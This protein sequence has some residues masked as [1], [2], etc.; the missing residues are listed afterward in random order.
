MT[1][2]SDLVLQHLETL[3]K[4]R[5][6]VATAYHQGAV[7][8]SDDPAGGKGIENLR[9]A[10]ILLPRNEGSYRL[11]S[12]LMRHLDETLQ[13]ERLYSSSGA[14]LFELAQRLPEITNMV[15]DAAYEGRIEDADHY[16]DEFDLKVFEIADSVQASLVTLRFQCDNNF[17]NVS[18][19]S[20]KQHQNEYYLERATR[21]SE[22]LSSIQSNNLAHALE[23]TPEGG[24]ML[25][26]YQ[27]QIAKHLS[28]WRAQLLDI[29]SILHAYL[30]K[31]RNIQMVA[32]RMRAFE[33]FLRRNPGFVPDELDDT[34]NLPDWIKRARSLPLKAHI[35][36]QAPEFDEELLNIAH[37]I[38]NT[39]QKESPPPRIGSLLP[40]APID[41]EE[42]IMAA[43]EWELAILA[44]LSELSTEPISAIE[45]KATKPKLAY[46]DDDIWLLC[47][48][49]E[50]E[51]DL[52]RN[53]DVRFEHVSLPTLQI[54]GNIYLVDIYLSRLAA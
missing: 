2:K 38:P 1:T 4:Y 26:T 46:I 30:H 15:A 13:K 53:A 12:S 9:Q 54:C 10:G 36:V 37:S 25:V 50:E 17:A 32:R 47:L 18:T 7:D 33:L 51:N 24:R 35:S 48:L 39:K 6:L 28:E 14:E 5:A 22:T 20:E 42:N 8:S 11:S 29:T 40:D 34:V 43:Q 23:S 45:W 41:T 49:R 27:S 16:I 3:F 52:A 19:F 44:F 31:T 21:I